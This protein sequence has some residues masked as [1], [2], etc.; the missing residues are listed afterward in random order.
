MYNLVYYPHKTLL[1]IAK[2]VKKFNANLETL[3]KAMRCIMD[4][5]KGVGIAA[6]QVN[7]SFRCFF[8]RL[9]E[10]YFIFVNPV[11]T[12]YSLETSVMEEGCL[13]IPRIYADVER[14]QAISIEAH[15]QK[16][17]LFTLDAEGYLAR[18]IQHEMNHLDGILFID[19][20]STSARK[21]A[22]KAY[23]N[24]LEGDTHSA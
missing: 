9:D 12:T 13:S 10:E 23:K 21:R 11:I 4:E 1:S 8:A 3:L 14:P 17:K 15:N 20:I 22:L 2:P 7:A 6:P 5:K 16:G 24:P 19:K 18:I